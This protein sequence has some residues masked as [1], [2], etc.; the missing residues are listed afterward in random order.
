[1]V[2]A[3]VIIV[4]LC[5][6]ELIFLCVLLS[7]RKRE[8]QEEAQRDAALRENLTRDI[9][10]SLGNDLKNDL[11]SEIRNEMSRSRTELKTT[12]DSGIQTS[13]K[14]VNSQLNEVFK[15]IGQIQALAG[16]VGDLKK[17]LSNVKTR[18]NLGEI[19]LGNILCEILAPEQYEE[20]AAVEEGSSER[21]DFAVK[22]PGQN[23]GETVYLPIDAKFPS[24]LYADLEDAREEGDKE[25]AEAAKK[26]LKERLKQEG[27]KIR[28]KYIKVPQT[29]D[30]AVMFLPS[31]GL[32]AEAVQMGM[33]ETLQHEYKVTIAGPSTMAALLNSLQMGFRTL[34]VQNRSAEV[35]KV[36]GKVKDEFGNFEKGLNKAQERMK[37]TSDELDKLVGVRTRAIN[38]ALKD[39]QVS[40]TEEG[41]SE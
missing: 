8:R 4:I 23:E 17:V 36:L 24:D 12:L 15:G 5:I 33:L 28:D 27:K 35:W 7:Q 29:T 6:V 3:L 38:K 41:I 10:N 32:Y 40:D 22:L 11:S 30:F 18:G 2:F 26:A 21:V 31:E 1:M 19:Q 9:K 13:F 37:Q 25:K 14:E 16:D 20:Q 34:A 39:V